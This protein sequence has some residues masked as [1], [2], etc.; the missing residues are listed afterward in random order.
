VILSQLLAKV[1]RGEQV[2]SVHRGHIVV[3]RPDGVTLATVG[4][5][6]IPSF[7][8]SAAKPVQVMPVLLSGA[9]KHFGFSDAELAVM[10]ASHNGEATH[11]QTVRSIQHKIG[12]D[13]SALQCG[14]HAPMHFDTAEQLTRKGKAVTALHNNCSGKHSGMIAGILHRGLDPGNYLDPSHPYQNEILEILVKFAGLDRTEIRIATDGCSAP[15]YFMPLVNMAL[16]YARLAE[17]RIKPA[18]RVFDIMSRHPFMIA[19]TDRFD[20]KI[21]EVMQ[22][23]LISKIGAEGIRCVGIR[24]ESPVAIA[25][26]IEDGNPRASGAVLLEALRQ[27]ELIGPA[28]LQTLWEFASPILRNHAGL[29]IGRIE[30]CFMMEGT[31]V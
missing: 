26:K 19:G 29:K 13:E 21:M 1:Y 15:N 20:T 22:T 31:T 3:A 27:L 28:E 5:P 10:M 8:R 9:D 18:R 16:I 23:R 2:E 17:G 11:T 4:D 30:P 25:L 24:G 14:V 7:I 6:S 12:I